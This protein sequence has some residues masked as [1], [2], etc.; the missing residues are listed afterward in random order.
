[1]KKIN[2]YNCH[3]E[4]QSTKAEIKCGWGEYSLVINGVKGYEC[5][6]C[7]SKMYAPE[8]I[9][10]VENIGKA[11][12]EN[13]ETEKP[14]YL[15]VTETADLLRVSTQTIYNQIRAN[16]IKAVKF[17]REWRFLRKNIESLIADDIG[18]AARAGSI[19]STDQDIINDVRHKMNDE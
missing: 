6:N 8:E 4:M 19:D 12:A 13:K 17:G 1:M 16:K 10:M 7:G 3:N 11:L 15:N 18:L 14:D 9:K 5:S 2:C